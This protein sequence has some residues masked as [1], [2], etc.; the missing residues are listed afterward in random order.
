MEQQ[1]MSF[2]DRIAE[3]GEYRLN[4]VDYPLNSFSEQAKYLL[5]EI[6]DLEKDITDHRKQHDRLA[7]ALDGFKRLLEEELKKGQ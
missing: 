7:L 1:E 6:V 5:G 4:G 3:Q 2:E